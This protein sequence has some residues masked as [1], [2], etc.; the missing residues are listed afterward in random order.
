MS[1]LLPPAHALSGP[2]V[3]TAAVVPTVT[4]QTD[5]RTS[6]RLHVHDV[7]VAVFTRPDGT[8]HAP[9]RG[10]EETIEMIGI[11]KE[12]RIIFRRENASCCLT[13][14]ARNW[15]AGS[16]GVGRGT[17][18]NIMWRVAGPPNPIQIQ[19]VSTSSRHHKYIRSHVERS[20]V[21][22]INLRPY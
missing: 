20:S 10:K 15:L 2:K 4:V 14:C 3:A 17:N 22:H 9:M 19:H 11:T 7:L 18:K 16:C 21:H 1:P 13:T 8:S 12:E 5:F 6:R